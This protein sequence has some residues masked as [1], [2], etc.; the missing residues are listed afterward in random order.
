MLTDYIH[1]GREAVLDGLV[2][3]MTLGMPA[4]GEVLPAGEIAAIL[5]F[6]KS[7]WPARLQAI[8]AGRNNG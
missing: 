4:F 1:R 2:V 6:I 3:A 7:Q 5:V 8:Q